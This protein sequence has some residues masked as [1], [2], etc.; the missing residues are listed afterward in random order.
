[1]PVYEI[2]NPTPI[3]VL[4]G[5]EP[6]RTEPVQAIQPVLRVR[7]LERRW[8]RS[9]SRARS[10]D[11]KAVPPGLAAALMLIDETND[12]LARQDIAIHLSLVSH[13]DFFSLEIYDCTDKQVCRVLEDRQIPLDELPELV[14]HL[15]GEAG[16]LIDTIT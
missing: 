5:P 9:G 12:V 1:M 10:Q 14:R 7:H 16:L 2:K 6:K 13:E 15:S 11:E 8:P 4:S 3:G